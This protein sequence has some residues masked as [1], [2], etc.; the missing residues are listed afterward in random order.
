MEVIYSVKYMKSKIMEFK[1]YFDR[2]MKE[3]NRLNFANET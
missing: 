2:V 1:E 3:V